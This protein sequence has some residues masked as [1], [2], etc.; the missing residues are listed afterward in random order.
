MKQLD[1][2]IRPLLLASV[3]FAVFS[4]VAFSVAGAPSRP[5]SAA[6]AM[7]ATTSDRRNIT[8]SQSGT[9][10]SPS[11]EAGPLTLADY[12]LLN[13][14]LCAKSILGA[15][16]FDHWGFQTV[17]GDLNGDGLSD[18]IISGPDV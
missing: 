10:T 14:A 9:N 5:A 13:H 12:D 15:E 11:L 8:V 4:Q 2:G 17:A 16:S 1:G 3:F 7:S 18:L 6:Q